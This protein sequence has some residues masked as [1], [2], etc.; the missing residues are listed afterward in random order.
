MGLAKELP[1]SCFSRVDTIDRERIEWLAS[2]NCRIVRIGIEAGNEEMRHH[3]YKK[4]ISNATY[5]EVIRLLHRN[6]IRVTG[7]NTLGGPG[8]TRETL[9]DTFR[10][11]KHLDIDRPIF[12]TYRPLPKTRGAELVSELGGKILEWKHI[13]SFHRRSNVSTPDLKPG[14]ILFFRYQYLVYFTLKRSLKLIKRQRGTFFVNL[15]RYLFRGL[16]DGVGMEYAIG[17]FYFCAGDN[18]LE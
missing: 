8:E 13:D 18:L 2:A 14:E 6:G 4:K 5:A 9:R 10:L 7:F 3:V 12:F 11:V 17:Y 16:R 1:F 15:F